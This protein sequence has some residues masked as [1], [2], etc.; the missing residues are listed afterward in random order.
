MEDKRSIPP[1]M[2]HYVD[3]LSLEEINL[4]ADIIEVMI[5]RKNYHNN[6]YKEKDTRIKLQ[7][8]L[9]N[10][11]LQKRDYTQENILSMKLELK[12]R[13]QKEFIEYLES[14]IDCHELVS[15][16]LFNH[17]KELKVYREVLQKYNEIIGN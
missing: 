9:E 1:F 10:I 6:W 4:V 2:K 14:E 17:N 11:K 7:E 8:Q 3:D 5:D 16:L 13:R 15:D 12:N